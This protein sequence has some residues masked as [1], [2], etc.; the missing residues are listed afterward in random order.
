M[1]DAERT[2]ARPAAAGPEEKRTL[3]LRAVLQ[4]VTLPLILGIA[5]LL[6]AWTLSWPAAWSLL[7]AY[8]G[9]MLLTNL[10]LV[11]R[12]PGLA[13][14]RL[15]IPR[16]SERWDLRIIQITNVLLLA[17]MLPLAGVDHRL[18]VSP[19]VP[20][21]VSLCA[22]FLFAAM[23]LFMAWAM[24]VN[25]YFSSAVRLQ[26]DR[27]QTV[28]RRGP[29]RAVRHPGYVAMI[30]QFLAIP[31]VLGSLWALIPAAAAAAVYVYRTR[32]EDDLLMHALAGYAE[33]SRQVPY[34]LIPGIW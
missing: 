14:E 27:G 33:Y 9:G 30:I 24:S 26:T 3:L 28:V 23:F 32:R 7:A 4:A 18:G 8:V 10:W 6:P 15:I 21:A 19:A 34:R 17:V 25:D 16:S 31:V 5:L 29:Y 12:H 2:T 20:A 1:T 22:L 11:A 13:R